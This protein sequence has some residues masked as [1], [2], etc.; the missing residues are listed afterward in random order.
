MKSVD[1]AEGIVVRV[2]R[3]SVSVRLDNGHELT[4]FVA[5]KLMHYRIWIT[6]GDRVTV[7]LAM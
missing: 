7:E 4:A 3:N 6:P 2:N 5:G 1:I